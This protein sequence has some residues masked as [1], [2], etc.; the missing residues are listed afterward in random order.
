MLPDVIVGECKDGSI[1]LKFSNL[2]NIYLKSLISTGADSEE[3]FNYLA[4]LRLKGIIQNND[5]N[6][7][8]E[9]QVEDQRFADSL[10]KLLLA[11]NDLELVL[12]YLTEDGSRKVPKNLLDWRSK[13]QLKK[14][15]KN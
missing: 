6:N 1:S 9:N 3:T 12:G 13:N 14:T 15:K 11:T 7:L 8:G 4:L 10:Y 2:L 5:E